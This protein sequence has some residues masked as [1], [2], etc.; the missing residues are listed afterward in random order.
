M[1]TWPSTFP[2]PLIEGTTYTAGMGVNRTKFVGGNSRVRRTQARMPHLMRLSF[3]ATQAQREAMLDWLK[4]HVGELIDLKLPTY[5]GYAS[6]P[7]RIVSELS[8]EPVLTGGSWAWQLSLDAVWVP[9]APPSN[10]SM[11]NYVSW[12]FLFENDIPSAGSLRREY[13][14]NT[15]ATVGQSDGTPA[16]TITSSADTPFGAN[17]ADFSGG[18]YTFLGCSGTLPSVPSDFHPHSTP[19]CCDLWI[20]PDPGTN[21]SG[22]IGDDSAQ[23]ANTWNFYSV[24]NHGTGVV[25]VSFRKTSTVTEAMTSP[26]GAVKMDQWQHVAFCG[27][28]AGAHALYVN[29]VQVATKTTTGG[30]PMAGTRFNVGA[31]NPAQPGF[32]RS[33]TGRMKAARCTVGHQRWVAGFTPPS[34]LEEY[35]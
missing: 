24:L 12:M 7:I 4:E 28:G 6:T 1:I 9:P 29:G 15:V 21:I 32:D 35:L 16:G 11:L 8:W 14:S 5:K 13:K 3:Y 27:N 31:H 19:Y 20:K 23:G 30:A 10:P 33:Y 26:G 25:Q 22:L 17:C 18:I 34:S 2:C